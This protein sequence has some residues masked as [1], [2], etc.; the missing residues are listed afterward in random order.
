[1]LQE[2]YPELEKLFMDTAQRRTQQRNIQMQIRLGT[3]DSDRN[4]GMLNSGK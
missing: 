2:R 3:H 4:G 1:M